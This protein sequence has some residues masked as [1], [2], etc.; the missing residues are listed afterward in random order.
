MVEVPSLH[1]FNLFGR[2]ALELFR[3]QFHDFLAALFRLVKAG[4]MAT[5]LSRARGGVR[6]LFLTSIFPYIPVVDIWCK[7]VVDIKRWSAF[8]DLR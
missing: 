2:L 1:F 4:I 5:H 7:Q 6:K 8:D 3:L